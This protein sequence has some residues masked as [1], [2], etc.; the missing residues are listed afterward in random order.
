VGKPQ[1]SSWL[2]VRDWNCTD[3]DIPDRK[4]DKI[5]YGRVERCIF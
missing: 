2:V 3:R 1:E 4:R 5:A